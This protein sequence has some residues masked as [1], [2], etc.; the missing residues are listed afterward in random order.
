MDTTF[1]EGDSKSLEVAKL[2]YYPWYNKDIFISQRCVEKTA[3]K[4]DR[5]TGHAIVTDVSARV[6]TDVFL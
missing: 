4:I 6:K 3:S 2:F 5:F 1:W